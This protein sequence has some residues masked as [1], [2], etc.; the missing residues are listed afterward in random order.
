MGHGASIMFEQVDFIGS[1]P[2]NSIIPD[3]QIP[4]ICFWGRSNV[5]K[6]SIIN[7]LCDRKE[8]AKVSTTPGKTIQFNA[9]NIDGNLI[10]MDLPGYGYAQVSKKVKSKWN[11]EI[12][13]YLQNRQNLSCLFLLVDIS[14]PPQAI[15]Q[16]VMKNL[17]L[18]KV[19]FIILFTKS[20]K[21]T[22]N[23]LG[24]SLKQH[25][26]KLEELWDPIPIY[27]ITSSAKRTGRTDLVSFI[28]DNIL[29]SKFD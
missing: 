9:F 14:I 1:Y 17:G 19:P 15:D 22:K 3:F 8:V 7:Y 6:S 5:G 24:K 18:M 25:I 12:Y 20:D 29:N 27:F 28:H 16:D 11:G 4:E 2:K 23:E 21:C 13:K 10:L 26:S